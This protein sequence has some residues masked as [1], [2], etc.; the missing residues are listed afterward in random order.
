MLKKPDECTPIGEYQCQVPMPLRGRIQGVDFCIA[1]I[2][3]ALNAAN[4]VTT[5]SCCGHGDD[6]KAIIMLDDGRTL[7]IDNVVKKESV[8]TKS[9]SHP[10]HTH[11]ELER[12]LGLDSD[13]VVID[14]GVFEQLSRHISSVEKK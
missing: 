7:H 6:S 3:A 4:I 9:L 8:K 5:M 11:P 12:S 13:H 14:V 1:D 2:V 10:L